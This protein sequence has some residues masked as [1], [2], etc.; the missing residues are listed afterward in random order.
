LGSRRAI[1]RTGS[2]AELLDLEA[3]RISARNVIQGL[4]Q[5]AEW[6]TTTTPALKGGGALV[7]T[8]GK[9][10]NVEVAT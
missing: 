3:D 4:K 9:T 6:M 10:T 7:D 8:H 5:G 1:G 2:R